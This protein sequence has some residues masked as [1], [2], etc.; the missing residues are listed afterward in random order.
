MWLPINTDRYLHFVK[1][2]SEGRS[3]DLDWGHAGEYDIG[4][5]ALL[6]D[7]CVVEIKSHAHFVHFIFVLF[8]NRKF[9]ERKRKPPQGHEDN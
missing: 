2:W 1:I 6:F 8:G 4:D 3:G 5:N 9:K 7:S